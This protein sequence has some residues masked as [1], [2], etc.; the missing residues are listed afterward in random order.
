MNAR[1]KMS[2]LYGLLTASNQ[3]EQALIKFAY[4]FELMIKSEFPE[5]NCSEE[6]DESE[7]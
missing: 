3:D 2:F 5:W 1:E 4:C 6:E 7:N